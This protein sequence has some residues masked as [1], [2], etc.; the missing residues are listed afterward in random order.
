MIAT[1]F[2]LQLAP[3]NNK[4]TARINLLQHWQ[5]VGRGGMYKSKNALM[6]V[7]CFRIVTLAQCSNFD[8]PSQKQIN[9]QQILPARILL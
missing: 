4:T 8:L 1:S 5:K 3:Q 9:T 6:R 7:D 2:V